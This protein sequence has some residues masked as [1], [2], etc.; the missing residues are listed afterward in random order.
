MKITNFAIV[1]ILMLGFAVN[2]VSAQKKAA[3]DSKITMDVGFHC[4]HGKTKIEKV[5]NEIDGVKS[6]T[7]NL[8]TKKVEVV[9]NPKVTS[10][11]KLQEAMLNMGYD[12]DGKKSQAK[13]K[14]SGHGDDHDHDHDHD[15]E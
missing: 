9:F 11:E 5:L 10:K 4:A 1:L 15:H 13:H 3:K 6:H 7:V 8:E 14:C 2:P 12:C